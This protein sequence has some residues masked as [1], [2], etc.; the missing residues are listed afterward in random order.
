MTPREALLHGIPYHLT[1]AAT[2]RNARQQFGLFW[3]FPAAGRF[4][5]DCHWLRLLGSINAPSG[6]QLVRAAE[7][8]QRRSQAARARGR[9]R[10]PV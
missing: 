1:P 3:R 9:S 2:T 6:G 7:P 8:V 10:M 5:T 4:A